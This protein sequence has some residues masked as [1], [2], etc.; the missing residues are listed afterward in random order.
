MYEAVPASGCVSFPWVVIEGFNVT[1]KEACILIG[2]KTELV[3]KV[4]GISRM[5]LSHTCRPFTYGNMTEL[6]LK[7]TA[8]VIAQS[9]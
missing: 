7:E 4:T 2:W 9:A 8:L 3:W 6:T 1:I 5:V